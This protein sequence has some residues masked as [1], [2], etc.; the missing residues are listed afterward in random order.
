MDNPKSA[1]DRGNTESPNQYRARIPKISSHRTLGK[2]YNGDPR[3]F[4]G[5]EDQWVTEVQI[6]RNEAAPLAL[7]N[8]DQMMVAC[9]AEAL[10]RD[11][12]DVVPSG[13]EECCAA[14]SQILVELDLHADST[15]ETST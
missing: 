15:T 6:E 12:G 7:A 2:L 8:G 10:L 5:P 1:G 13:A 4:P 3:V 9:A 14:L 11:G